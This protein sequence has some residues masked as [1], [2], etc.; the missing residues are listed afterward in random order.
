VYG[1][2]Q[3]IT[4]RSRK[5]EDLIAGAQAPPLMMAFAPQPE[6]HSPMNIDPIKTF[7]PCSR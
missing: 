7:K 2:A 5:A 1:L 3:A 4:I 6:Q